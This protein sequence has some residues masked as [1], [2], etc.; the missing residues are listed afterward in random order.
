MACPYGHVHTRSQGVQGLARKD[1]LL[2][3]GQPTVV[4]WGE[5]SRLWKTPSGADHPLSEAV[6]GHQIMQL[7]G[8]VTS[9]SDAAREF[10]KEL[11][12][13]PFDVS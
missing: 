2:R 8:A 5:R 6:A 11:T 13:D 3:C 4:E 1:A 10:Q 9:R 7:C 12:T